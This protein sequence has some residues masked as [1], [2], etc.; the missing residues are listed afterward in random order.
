MEEARQAAL[1]RVAERTRKSRPEIN[2][3]DE[4][5][6]EAGRARRL[7]EDERS[8]EQARRRAVKRAAEYKKQN[9]CESPIGGE[10]PSF[11]K[12]LTRG[13]K[14]KA[15]K[16]SCEQKSVRRLRTYAKNELMRMWQKHVDEIKSV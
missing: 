1:R 3:S 8:L 10:S 16:E 13:E 15:W 2:S 5:E 6:T 4:D 14:L 12:S 9:E 7:S 11:R